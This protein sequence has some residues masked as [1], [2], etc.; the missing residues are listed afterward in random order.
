M[1]EIL[2]E[3]SPEFRCSLEGG[4]SGVRVSPGVND[5]YTA[6]CLFPSQLRSLRGE[7]KDLREGKETKAA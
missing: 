6:D 4:G 2:G 1:E 3:V 7:V 5:G